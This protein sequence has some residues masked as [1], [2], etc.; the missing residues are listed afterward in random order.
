MEF[1]AYLLLDFNLFLLLHVIQ[2]HY[3]DNIKAQIIGDG[4][5]N[6]KIYDINDH[7]EKT[8]Q[9]TLLKIYYFR[10]QLYLFVILTKVA[11]CI[12]DYCY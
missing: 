5:L 12:Y 9:L 4:S 2:K 10:F 3:F 1:L 11:I 8:K 7:I 6:L